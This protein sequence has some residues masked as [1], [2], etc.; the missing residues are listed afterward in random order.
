MK[1]REECGDKRWLQCDL[2]N[3]DAW[4]LELDLICCCKVDDGL[5]TVLKWR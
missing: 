4:W 5:F 1:Q 3:S 2:W